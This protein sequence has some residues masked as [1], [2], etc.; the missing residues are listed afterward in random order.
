MKNNVLLRLSQ[1]KTQQSRKFS[2]RKINWILPQEDADRCE[3]NDNCTYLYCVHHLSKCGLLAINCGVGKHFNI[4]PNTNHKTEIF[5]QPVSANWY[6]KLC[7][8]FLSPS[9]TEDSFVQGRLENHCDV[10]FRCMFV[11]A[12]FLY[13]VYL[14][15]DFTKLLSRCLLLWIMWFFV[16]LEKLTDFSQ[17][18]LQ[19]LFKFRSLVLNMWMP[20]EDVVK[21][22]KEALVDPFSSQTTESVLT[23]DLI[24][25]L[26]S[27]A[28]CLR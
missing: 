17:K 9:Y 3:R 2:P 11:D 18:L 21:Y 16:F 6:E 24:G 26:S 22:K 27:L 19:L 23:K 1:R 10:S 8:F 20:E 25:D 28:R 12:G 4:M 5:L 7:C 15:S 13:R 14:G